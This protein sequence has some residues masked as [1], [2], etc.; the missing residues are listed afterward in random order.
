MTEPRGSRARWSVAAV[1]APAAA[2]AFAGSTGW[3][4]AHPPDTGGSPSAAAGT[5]A[6]QTAS[7]R[8]VVALQ[9]QVAERQARLAA[10]ADAVRTA[11]KQAATLAAAPQ[12]GG[13]SYSSGSA[14][15]SAGGNTRGSSAGSTAG[16][17]GQVTQV[18]PPPPP[19]THTSTGASGSG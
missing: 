19:P 8:E 2:A 5:A 11:R 14:Q 7:Y 10:L 1:V 16:T 3:A 9:A 18:A 6:E 4:L 12:A 15:A 13:E 17:S